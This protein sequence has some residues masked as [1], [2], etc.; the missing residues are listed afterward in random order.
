MVRAVMEG[1]A[2]NLRWLLPHVERFVGRRFPTLNFI[3]GGAQS[4]AWPQILADVLDRPIRCVADPRSANVRGAALL[5]LVALNHIDLKDIASRV[6]ILE[7]LQ[8]NPA[9]RACYDR[10]GDAFQQAFRSN[11]GIFRALNAARTKE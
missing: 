8:P 11:R 9:N 10:H 5:A 7:E 2:F 1:V 4:T 3:G 6:A